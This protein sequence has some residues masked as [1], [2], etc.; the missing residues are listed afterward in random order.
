MTDLPTGYHRHHKGG[1]YYVTGTAINTTGGKSDD[2]QIMVMYCDVPM[3]HGPFV[4]DIRE[5]LEKFEPFEVKTGIE[6][7]VVCAAIRANDGELLLGI[8][9]YSRDMHRQIEQRVD[10]YK[11]SK[12][13][14]DD[15]GFVDQH[16]AWMSRA[17]AYEVA[18]AA[19]QIVRPEACKEGLDVGM[20]LYSEGL[21]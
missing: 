14:D 11:F 17:E 10:G 1:L 16:G 4:R 8:R 20:K 13:H 21:Y 7:R 18:K 12:R 6:R 15:Q 19:R 9:H 2:P 5:F 3:V